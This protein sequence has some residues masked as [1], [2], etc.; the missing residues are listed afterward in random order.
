[1]GRM[2]GGRPVCGFHMDSD[3]HIP[4]RFDFEECFFDPSN[5]AN[6]QTHFISYDPSFSRGNKNIMVSNSIFGKEPRNFILKFQ[7]DKGIF[8]RINV[9]SKEFTVKFVLCTI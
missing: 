8:H 5:Q 9:K 4:L 3:A 7:S 6:K 1:M 2:V